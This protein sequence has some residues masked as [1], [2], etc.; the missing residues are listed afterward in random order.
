MG[1]V[2]LLQKAPQ[3][4]TWASLV[5]LFHKVQA[6]DGRREDGTQSCPS[7]GGRGGW[8][9][10]LSEEMLG[11]GGSPEW[12]GQGVGLCLESAMAPR[13]SAVSI[14][15]EHEAGKQVHPAPG[16]VLR[17][18]AFP[19]T[20]SSCTPTSTSTP[21]RGFLPLH[22]VGLPGTCVRSAILKATSKPSFLFLGTPAGP[23]HLA[24]CEVGG[25]VSAFSKRWLSRRFWVRMTGRY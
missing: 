3:D 11:P 16:T 15:V 5:L 20:S 19:G 9:T 14:C 12:Q 8:K 7:Y 13:R 18:A 1:W 10:V 6:E 17:W 22:D 2:P 24:T 4:P 25:T 21:A 23:C